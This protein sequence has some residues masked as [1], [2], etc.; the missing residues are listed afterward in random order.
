M[1]TLRD[2][3]AVIFSKE[4]K[5]LHGLY[6][7]SF[8]RQLNIEFFYFFDLLFRQ[9]NHYC[10][11]RSIVRMLRM[12]CEELDAAH[13]LDGLYDNIEFYCTRNAAALKARDGKDLEAFVERLKI[14]DEVMGEIGF[15]SSLEGVYR[16]FE[17]VG[18]GKSQDKHGKILQL[19]IRDG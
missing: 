19:K 2:L 1:N 9:G 3:D 5:D 14:L 10:Y 17:E 6:Q 13:Y 11:M 8:R 12:A 16:F 15:Y 18:E 4:I 7:E